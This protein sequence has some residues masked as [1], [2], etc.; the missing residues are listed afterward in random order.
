MFSKNYKKGLDAGIAKVRQACTAVPSGDVPFVLS[1]VPTL[2]IAKYWLP[3]VVDMLA[4]K[5][6]AHTCVCR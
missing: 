5:L 2:K 1:M 4:L 6:S 3:I